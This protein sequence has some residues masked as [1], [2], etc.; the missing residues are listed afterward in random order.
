MQ[1]VFEVLRA[2]CLVQQMHFIISKCNF[3]N[4]ELKTC[5]SIILFCTFVWRSLG[6][7][8]DNIRKSSIF[9]SCFSQITITLKSVVLSCFTSFIMSVTKTRIGLC[10]PRYL[11][12]QKLGYI[13]KF[14]GNSGN[15]CM[16][17]NFLSLLVKIQILIKW[18]WFYVRIILN[19]NEF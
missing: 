4:V 6:S 18:L 8:W 3:K 14:L 5:S 15:D 17:E 11:Y 13:Q 10:G 12:T 19:L 7:A 9:S 2:K 1:K 16:I